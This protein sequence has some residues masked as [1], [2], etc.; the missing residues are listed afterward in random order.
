MV[1]EHLREK[2]PEKW[3][4]ILDKFESEVEGIPQAFLDAFREE[5]P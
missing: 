2:Y 5:K 4:G 1:C 3:K